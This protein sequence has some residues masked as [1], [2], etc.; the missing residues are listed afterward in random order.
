MMDDLQLLEAEDEASRHETIL[1]RE[2]APLCEEMRS[3]RQHRARL[4]EERH[5]LHA[6]I[7]ALYS[8]HSGLTQVSPQT[9]LDFT[10]GRTLPEPIILSMLL[11]NVPQSAAHCLTKRVVIEGEPAWGADCI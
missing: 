2:F 9:P 11:K 10:Q 5:E 1:Q 4:L 8:Q 6:S 7:A 3:L